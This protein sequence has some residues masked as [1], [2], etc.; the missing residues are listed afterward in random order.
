MRKLVLIILIIVQPIL[1]QT[2]KIVLHTISG[3][4][5][6]YYLS[7]IDKMTF[8]QEGEV[9]LIKLYLSS[10]TSEYLN[11]SELKK[12]TFG[13]Y[14]M[15]TRPFYIAYKNGTLDSIDLNHIKEIVID[16]V[17]DVVDN[18]NDDLTVDLI[19]PLPSRNNVYAELT[20]KKESYIV[21]KIFDLLG[22]N[23]KNL[24]SKNINRGNH[25]ITWDRTNNRMN[26][27]PAGL[28]FLKV[29]SG[30]INLVKK[31]IIE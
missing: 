10:G 3:S 21:V 12:I 30:K 14:G 29:N 6:N 5:N 27:M 15:M 8:E 20:L 17:S 13:P 18:N 19:F 23:I 9:K 4:V 22:N 1:A 7:D 11:I 25:L 31:F 28:Y 26:K 2:E 24:F 16:P